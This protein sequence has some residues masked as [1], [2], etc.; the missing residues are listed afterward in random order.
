M[1]GRP[2]RYAGLVG[3][4]VLIPA[5]LSAAP[6]TLKWS[7]TV[8]SWPVWT[9]NSADNKD[10]IGSPD[11]T[12]GTV[13][14]NGDLLSSISFNFGGTWDYGNKMIPGDL[15]LDTDGDNRWD[16]VVSLYG[17]R[18]NSDEQLKYQPVVGN[19]SSIPVY[20]ITSLNIYD[21]LPNTNY[22]ITGPDNPPTPDWWQGY[23]IRNGHPYAFTY[24]GNALTQVGTA[25]LNYSMPG[26]PDYILGSP[27]IFDLTLSNVR[28]GAGGKL[29]FGFAENCA[30]DVILAE[31]QTPEPSPLL[32]LGVGLV[33][34]AAFT[35]RRR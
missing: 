16:Y 4:C 33:L 23:L 22:L 8:I 31:V 17:N 3:C 27:L 14:I 2:V 1:A 18:S 26:P 19:Y 6:I 21:N 32:L 13:V 15:F 9:V 10:S 11:I 25:A 20:S 30:N 35:R 28:L 24:G 34:S 12:G 29:Q 7:D 5:L